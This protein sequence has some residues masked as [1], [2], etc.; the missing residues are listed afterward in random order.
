MPTSFAT[1][2]NLNPAVY[3]TLMN[4]H[5]QTP[6]DQQFGLSIQHE[7]KGT[8]IEARYVGNH[9]TKL[10]RGFDLNQENI[11]SNGFLSDFQKAQNNGNLALAGTGVFNP[12][13]NPRIPGSQ[14]LQRFR[15]ALAAAAS[16]GD[17]TYDVSNTKW[18]SRRTGLSIHP[19]RRER[20]SEFLSESEC[21]ERGVPG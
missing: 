21:A 19:Q 1:Q 7:I 15:A 14:P 13:Y 8:I 20:K 17:P 9:A 3:F 2:Y 12:A 16:L 11:T 18:R 5:L 4:P 10:L 6:Y